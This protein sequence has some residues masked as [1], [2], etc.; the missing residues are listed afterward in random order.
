MKHVNIDPLLFRK[1]HGRIDE[2][3]DFFDNSNGKALPAPIPIDRVR[4]K[5][6]SFYKKM[7]WI[8]RFLEEHQDEVPEEMRINK[9]DL[10]LEF[11][12]DRRA[13]ARLMRIC[14]RPDFSQMGV[15]FGLQAANGDPLKEGDKE[16]GTM[17][18][19]FMGL[20]EERNVLDCHFP[21]R[22]LESEND[23]HIDGEDT[24]PPPPPPPPPPGK[25]RKNGTVKSEP[26]KHY[27]SLSSKFNEI[28]DYFED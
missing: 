28:E 1:M 5:V 13:V 10:K 25:K 26:P 2:L 27:F 14:M 19:I 4:T 11:Y 18:G 20:D 9:D 21:L 22:T 3:K 8:A 15:F 12:I 24:W 7:N 16:F 17:T 23:E 6:A